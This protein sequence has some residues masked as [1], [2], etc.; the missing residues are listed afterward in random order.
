M[1]QTKKTQK[2]ALSLFSYFGTV[3][4]EVRFK[5]TTLFKKTNSVYG[6]NYINTELGI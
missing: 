4:K 6:V 1:W 2:K 3:L 5:L